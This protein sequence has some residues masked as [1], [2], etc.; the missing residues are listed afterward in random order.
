MHRA[1]RWRFQQALRKYIPY[2]VKNYFVFPVFAGAF[3]WKILLGNALAELVRDVYSALTFV[4]GHIGEEQKSWP[5]GTRPSGRGEWYAMQIEATKNFEVSLP[6]SLLCGGVDRHIEH[7]LF[8]RLPPNRLR[9]I[10]PEVRSICEKHGFCY[11]TDTWGKTLLKAFHQLAVL[12]RGTTTAPE[13][14]A[15]ST[16]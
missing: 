11:H 12:G 16:S 14:V 10:A 5:V 4:C 2:Y 6:V 13:S 1:E 15:G 8:P 9:Q 7:H 3:F